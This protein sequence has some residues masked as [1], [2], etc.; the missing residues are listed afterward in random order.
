MEGNFYTTIQTLH[1]FWKETEYRNFFI[2]LTP[3]HYFLKLNIAC[4]S[5]NAGK[6]WAVYYIRILR[7]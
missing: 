4:Y 5:K 3:K 6:L 1:N 7:C 2:I